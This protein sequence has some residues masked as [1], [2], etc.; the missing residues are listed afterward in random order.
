MLEVVLAFT[1]WVISMYSLYW[2]EVN[3]IWTAETAHRDKM[4]VVIL[5]SGMALSFLVQSRIAKGKQK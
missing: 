3:Q 1:P 4:A 2:I 5:A